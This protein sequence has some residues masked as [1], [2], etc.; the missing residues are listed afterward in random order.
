MS[1]FHLPTDVANKVYVVRKQLL[2]CPLLGDNVVLDRAYIWNNVHIAN[3]VD[4]SQSVVCDGAEVKVGV[5]LNKQCVL[6]YN[7]SSKILSM[8]IDQDGTVLL[9][10]VVVTFPPQGL[11]ELHILF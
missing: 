10:C 7:V 2:Y 1:E 3:N 6:A 9:V 8:H 5:R 4:I 11:K